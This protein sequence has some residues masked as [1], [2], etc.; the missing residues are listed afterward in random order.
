MIEDYPRKILANLENVHK[1][2]FDKPK[3]LNN[4]HEF[5]YEIDQ[6]AEY[7]EGLFSFSKFKIGDTVI[8]NKTPII[9]NE[10]SH[11][12]IGY[13]D[14]LVKGAKAKVEAVDYFKSRGFVYDLM[15]GKEGTFRFAQKDLDAKNTCSKNCYCNR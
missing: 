8:L 2:I 13:K 4:Q 9:T 10:I 7:V 12:W 14:I 6:L 3:I 1:W 5:K 15:F 11:G